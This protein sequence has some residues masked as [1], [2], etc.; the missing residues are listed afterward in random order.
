M[1]TVRAGS[2]EANADTDRDKGEVVI[3]V[4]TPGRI[5]RQFMPEEAV[6][7][8][9]AARRE[10]LLALRCMIDAA[11]AKIDESSA[12]TSAASNRRTEIPIQ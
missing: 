1:T 5:M 9:Q 4:P 11:I 2:F 12:S 8:M 6:K 3:R 7:H 10:Q